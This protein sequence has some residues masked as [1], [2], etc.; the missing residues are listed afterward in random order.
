MNSEP[1]DRI[2]KDSTADVIIFDSTVRI[3]LDSF[4]F[5]NWVDS[6]FSEFKFEFE[7]TLTRAFNNDNELFLMYVRVRV[8]V[9][10]Y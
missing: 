3:N 6:E 9:R 4:K 1:M 7:S 8:R 5:D 10:V 2:V